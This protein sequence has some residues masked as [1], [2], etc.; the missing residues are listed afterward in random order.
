MRPLPA[1]S[2]L[3]VSVVG[4]AVFENLVDSDSAR[5]GTPE[6]FEEALLAAPQDT[7]LPLVLPWPDQERGRSP[8][9]EFW[10]QW[11]GSNRR[12]FGVIDA[13]F[14][15]K[16]RKLG[17]PLRHSGRLAI[18]NASVARPSLEIHLHPWGPTAILTYDI[19]GGMDLSSA[20]AAADRT[21]AD[22]AN[23]AIADASL[24]STNVNDALGDAIEALHHIL[25]P[26]DP[27]PETT[28][29]PY[30]V[31]TVIEGNP[32]ELPSA[33]PPDRGPEHR[34]LHTLARGPGVLSQLKDALL[35]L[36]SGTTY[37]LEPERLHYQI[38]AGRAVWSAP[39]LLA[40]PVRP[41][42]QLS[43][44]H[45]FGVLRIAQLAS[46][47]ELLAYHR[48]GDNRDVVRE[49]VKHACLQLAREYGPSVPENGFVAGQFLDLSGGAT[50]YKEITG[51]ELTYTV[52]RPTLS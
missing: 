37:V 1:V 48:T 33:F 50:L 45:R 19:V 38:R 2:R 6:G 3:R 17:V 15:R 8:D 44:V 18:A 22:E 10:L 52:K 9:V 11:M 39:E 51:K 12:R 47:V 32:G 34:A 40:V 43:A 26:N 5:L 36:Y 28:V 20:S 49:A 16:L 14:G 4:P 29:Q 42:E 46:F 23:V 13:G 7:P 41:L 25:L 35:G 31:A 27:S 30:V 24:P 21:F